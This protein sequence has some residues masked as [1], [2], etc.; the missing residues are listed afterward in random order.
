MIKKSFNDQ[1]QTNEKIE[2]FS[3][4]MESLSKDIED[5]KKNPME[6]LDLKNIVI[7]KM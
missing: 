1:L 3:Q 5:I 6:N 7:T 4:E 2:S